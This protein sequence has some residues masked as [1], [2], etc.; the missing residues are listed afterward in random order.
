MPQYIVE[1]GF[2]VGASTST[3]LTLD[4]PVRGKLDTGTL[5]GSDVFTDI[6]AYV[7]S[8]STDRGAKRIESA[9]MRY[10]PGTATILL[11]DPDR[12]FDPTNLSGPYVAGGVSQVVPMVA[13]RIR[14]VYAGITYDVFRGFA[15]NW[16]ADYSGYPATAYVTL[17]ATD[18][19]K[20]LQD[21]I[22]QAVS[23]VGA[24]EDSGARVDRILDSISWPETDRDISVGDTTLQSTDLSGN[25]LE[26]LQTVQDTEAGE[27]Y[28]DPAGRTKFRNRLAMLT[29]TRSKTSQAT[30]SG[31]DNATLPIHDAKTSSDDS[32]MVNLALITREGG[33]EQVSQDTASRSQFLTKARQMSGLLMQTD[34]AAKDLG[35]WLVYQGKD[36]ETRITQIVLV[37]AKREA[38]LY[39]QMLG[40]LLGDR[41]T[42]TISPPGSGSI[43]RDCFIRGI[44][45]EVAD[46]KWTTTFVLQSAA[47]Y[48][49][50]VLDD[51][52]LGVLDANALAY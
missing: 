29:D 3:Y 21:H 35:N 52:V 12:R 45:H 47:K 13:V 38:N 4:D 18:A 50:L 34:G 7:Q 44:S 11:K 15:D 33:V 24:G 5:A 22:R 41:I 25:A 49:F 23:V 27:F 30:F 1:A 16:D 17:T 36:P 48:A 8:W 28:I 46:E 10:D 32:T 14:A 39:P 9:V 31:L 42:A 43:T 37:G 26:E 6:S 40:R 51:P 19:F 20:V 2:S